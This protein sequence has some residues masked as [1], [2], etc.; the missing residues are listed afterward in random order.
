[1]DHLISQMLLSFL[2]SNFSSELNIC[3][4]DADSE[5]PI[6]FRKKSI[7]V[8]PEWPEIHWNDYIEQV[9]IW[10]YMPHIV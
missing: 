7:S 6:F 8:E 10:V 4:A 1:M 2:V 3:F 5:F 9:E